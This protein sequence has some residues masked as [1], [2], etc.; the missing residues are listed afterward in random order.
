[1]F[2]ELF[3]APRNSWENATLVVNRG[4]RS[5]CVFEEGYL[6]QKYGYWAEDDETGEQGFLQALSNVFWT[7]D[8][9]AEARAARR[10]QSRKV[11]RG[12]PKGK[13]KRKG[14]CKKGY[15]FLR[16]KGGGKG[17][18][19]F[20]SVLVTQEQ[21]KEYSNWATGGKKGRK[22]KG[23]SKKGKGKDEAPSGKK[24][25]ELDW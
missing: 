15:R 9:E 6:D 19:G 11:R 18:K 10:F 13:G 12:A 5:F 2:M 7:F 24:V 17:K 4:S 1:M 3:C 22:G 8:D 16:R 25:R 14:K 21:Y 20:P 23:K